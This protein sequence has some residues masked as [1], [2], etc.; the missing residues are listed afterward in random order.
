MSD[1]DDALDS[2]MLEQG[3]RIRGEL[4]EAVLV[5]LRLGR[6][7]ESDLIGRHHPIT[8]LTEHANGGLPRSRAEVLPVQQH[9]RPAIGPWR[10][11]V[12]VAHVQRL[13]LRFE[14]ETLHRIGVVESLQFGSVSR[15]FRPSRS[16][17]EKEQKE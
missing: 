13:A 5:A 14:I 10:T 16:G 15:S 8:G 12:E 9:D 17:G 4:L 3:V 1:Q 7:A 11:D 2:E 6:L